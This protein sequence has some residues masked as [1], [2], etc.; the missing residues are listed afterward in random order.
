MNE[1][2]YE[3]DLEF[4]LLPTPRGWLLKAV[5]QAGVGARPVLK[6][7]N[8]LVTPPGWGTE[9]RDKFVDELINLPKEIQRIDAP[10]PYVWV[11]GRTKTDGPQDYNAVHK[12]QAGF[13]VIP[14]SEWGKPPRPVEVKIDPGVDMKTPPKI[15]VDTMTAGAYFTYAAKS[16]KVQPPHL[17]DEPIIAQMRRIGIVAGKSFDIDKIARAVKKGL[18]SA[19]EDGQKLMAWKVHTLAKVANGWSMNT[20]T[21]GV[22]GNYYLK[23]RRTLQLIWIAQ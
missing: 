12:I 10:T 11:I 6:L 16:L 9:L 1:R 23:R 18:E 5:N 7:K 3:S 19:P 2:G 8:F 15:Q 17:T 20:D 4:D 21:M 13:K 22:Y 14:L